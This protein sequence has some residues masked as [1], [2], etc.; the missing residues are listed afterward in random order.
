M[1]LVRNDALLGSFQPLTAQ[2]KSDMGEGELAVSCA[3]NVNTLLATV[4]IT[5]K[6][7]RLTASAAYG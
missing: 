2:A 3:S 1:I 4:N 5:V 7:T 6:N